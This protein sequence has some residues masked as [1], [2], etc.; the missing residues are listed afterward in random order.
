MEQPDFM[1]LLGLFW[2]LGWTLIG[3]LAGST[4]E[5]V[6]ARMRKQTAEAAEALNRALK[7]AAASFDPPTPPPRRRF[8]G[9][10]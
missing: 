1:S 9:L 4:Y 5:R 3:Y 2:A 7:E 10:N 6:R 8:T